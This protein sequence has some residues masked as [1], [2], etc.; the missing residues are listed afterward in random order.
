MSKN[1]LIEIDG[2]TH[3]LVKICVGCMLCSLVKYENCLEITDSQ[4]LKDM[5]LYWKLKNKIK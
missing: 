1:P 3:E 2:Q 5:Y 4:C